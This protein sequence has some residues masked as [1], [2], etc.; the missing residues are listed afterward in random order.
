MEKGFRTRTVRATV[1][2]LREGLNRN[3]LP[4][5]TSEIPCLRARPD[6]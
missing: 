3:L 6:Q 4:L 5:S 1:Q 2:R